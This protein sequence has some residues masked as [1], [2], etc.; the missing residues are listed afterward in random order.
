MQRVRLLGAVFAIVQFWLYVPPAGI[1]TPFDLHA[2]GLVMAGALVVINILSAR[3]DRLGG[4]RYRRHL[5][6]AGLACDAAVVATVVWLFRFDTTSALWGLLVIPVLEAAVAAQMAGALTMWVGLTVFYVLRELDAPRHFDYAVFEA[7]SVTFRMGIVLIVATTAGSLARSLTR[8]AWAQRAA[9]V[10]SQKRARLLHGLALSSNELLQAQ[11]RTDALAVWRAIIDATIDVGFEGASICVRDADADEYVVV[12]GQ[13]LPAG[14]I[15]TT[16]PLCTGLAGA[17]WTSGETQIVE[18]YSAWT[19]AC[20]GLRSVAFG[21]AVAVPIL[22][23]LDIKAVLVAAY[24]NPG[25]IPRPERECVELL[26]VHA[27][28]ALSNV[29]HSAERARF[30]ARLT[31]MAY[32]DGLTT[33]PNREILLQRLQELVAGPHRDGGVAVLFIDIDRFKVVNDTL[34]HHGGD[35]LLVELA[36]RLL[37]AADPHLVVRFGGDEFIVLV[38][39]CPDVAA[40]CEVGAQLSRRLAVPL[41]VDGH[42]IVPSVSVGIRWVEDGDRD[43]G[44]ILRDADTAM[45]L[46]KQR[47]RQRVEVFDPTQVQTLPALTLESEMRRG[48]P[49]GEFEL[50]YQPIVS[51]SDGRIRSVEALLRWRHPTRGMV[52][53]NDFIP[54]AEDSGFI[55]ELGA[56]VLR[57]A[58]DQAQQWRADG[59]P[60]AVAVNV[61][62]V[63]LQHVAFVDTLGAT[64]R[65]SGLRSAD[66]IIEITESATVTD[67]DLMLLQAHRIG[68]LGVRLALDDFGQ[69]TTSLRLI[70][71]LGPDVLKIDKSLVDEIL[72]DGDAAGNQAAV[73]RAMIQLAHD[74]GIVVTAEGVEEQP[75]LDVLKALGCDAAQGYLLAR[76]MPAND[77]AAVVDATQIV[78]S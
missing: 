17:V 52:P 30:E 46:A 66:L 61:S 28:V 32:T 72:L 8:E 29:A 9:N 41:V 15:G 43:A 49:A 6:L 24:R 4:D 7:P 27:G 69:G 45:Y 77:V 65:D 12:C 10:E 58:C 56:W 42:E 57:E 70:R 38:E 18:H 40:A 35:A 51:L 47:G 50:H 37:A 13:G 14:Y 21:A 11:S 44:E 48:L 20:A 34:G 78:A 39:Q 73:V 59:L 31:E 26:A 53:P 64:L 22:Q 19:D 55:V 16:F 5:I 74:L 36:R 3:L 33:L 1:E 62:V 23:A 60:L 76:P 71:R 75:Q 54:V 68:D 2:T 25:E 63:Q 67:A